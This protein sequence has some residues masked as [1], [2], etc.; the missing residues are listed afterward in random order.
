MRGKVQGVESQTYNKIIRKHGFC[1][2][3]SLIFF[4][5]HILLLF[6]Y[7][8][9]YHKLLAGYKVYQEDITFSPA[10]VFVCFVVKCIA[11]GDS[12][13]LKSCVMCGFLS[14]FHSVMCTQK[15]LDG[16]IDSRVVV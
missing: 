12:S 13:E 7:A 2:Q 1:K 15:Q 4:L 11:V 10:S 5:T 6:L 16:A 14:V 9:A 8:A 3:P